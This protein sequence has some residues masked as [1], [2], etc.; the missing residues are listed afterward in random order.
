MTVIVTAGR[1]QVLRLVR[2]G[3]DLGAVPVD[4]DPFRHSF[5]IGRVPGEGPLG[6]WYRVE[7][8]DARGRTAIGNPVFLQGS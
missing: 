4:A 8:S 7:T 3:D 1:G 6:T 2:N 5:S